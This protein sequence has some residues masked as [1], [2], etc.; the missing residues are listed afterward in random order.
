MFN[1]MH[2]VLSPAASHSG[3]EDHMQSDQFH[4]LHHVYFECNYGTSGVPYDAWFGTYRDKL[5][6]S[7]S[8][9]GEAKGIAE[10]SDP[11]IEKK[12]PLKSYRPGGKV[13]LQDAVPTTHAFLYYAFTFVY[14]M[15]ICAALRRDNLSPQVASVLAGVLTVLPLV[16]ASILWWISKDS[17]AYLW[18]FQKE[19][20]ERLAFHVMASGAMCLLPVYHLFY[21]S[22]VEQS[23]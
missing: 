8:Y 3:W 14:F 13:S 15:G 2:L 22:L 23:R 1:G 7:K 6:D 16:A 18:P 4:Y 17:L 19:S 9:Q 5:G 10:V 20:S 11:S 12:K 21:M